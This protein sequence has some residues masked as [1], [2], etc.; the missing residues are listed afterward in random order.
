MISCALFLLSDQSD[1][2]CEMF[3]RLLEYLP[4]L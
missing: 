3:K 4:F 2:H 1:V